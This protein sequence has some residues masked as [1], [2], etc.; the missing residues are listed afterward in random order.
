VLCNSGAV[1]T[2]EHHDLTFTSYISSQLPWHLTLR[3]KFAIR[4]AHN[5]PLPIER[6]AYM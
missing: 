1:R 6:K 5:H 2:L 4:L 3:D